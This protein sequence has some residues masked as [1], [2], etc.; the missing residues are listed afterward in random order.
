[1][2]FPTEAGA[3]GLHYSLVLIHFY[4]KCGLCLVLVRCGCQP[5][6][7]QGVAALAAKLDPFRHEICDL[8]VHKSLGS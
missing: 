1:M 7:L 3:G 5:A 8:G 4:A 6:S 2:Y